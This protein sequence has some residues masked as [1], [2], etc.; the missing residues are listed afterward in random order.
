[1]SVGC[2][3]AFRSLRNK[4]DVFLKATTRNSNTPHLAFHAFTVQISIPLVTLVNIE[5]EKK[6]AIIRTRRRNVSCA[7]VL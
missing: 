7:V 5:N 4:N 3:K 6:C 1:M 2:E